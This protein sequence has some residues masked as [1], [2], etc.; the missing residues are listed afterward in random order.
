MLRAFLFLKGFTQVISTPRLLMTDKNPRVYTQGPYIKNRVLFVFQFY[1]F[2][3]F[4]SA[5]QFHRKGFPLLFTQY[6]A[7]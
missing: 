3:F 5:R 7:G 2:V 4:G 1:Q 6:P